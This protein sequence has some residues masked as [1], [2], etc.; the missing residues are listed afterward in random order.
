[1]VRKRQDLAGFQ[2][3]AGAIVIVRVAGLAC[4]GAQQGQ[5]QR[6]GT[7]PRAILSTIFCLTSR[8]SESV[9]HGFVFNPASL[10]AG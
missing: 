1:M 10:N 3:L 5:Q 4:P 7:A 8:Y 6:G 9:F 2:R